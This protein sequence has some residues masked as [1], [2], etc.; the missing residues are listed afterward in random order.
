MAS[1]GLDRGAV[2][3]HVADFLG[4]KTGRDEVPGM[5][6]K[7]WTR[8][9]DRAFKEAFKKHLRCPHPVCPEHHL[10]GKVPSTVEIR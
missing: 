5:P 4:I 2:A 6:H 9:Q 1:G 3:G 7:T 10:K 8:A